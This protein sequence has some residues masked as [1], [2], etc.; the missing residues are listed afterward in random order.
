LIVRGH[1]ES[2]SRSRS[3]RRDF[4]ADGSRQYARK[5]VQELIDKTDIL[6]RLPRIGQVVPELGDDNIRFS[7]RRHAGFRHR[8]KYRLAQVCL[9]TQCLELA[10]LAESGPPQPEAAISTASRAKRA[11]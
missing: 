3:A 11:A 1:G 5:V 4:I 9:F 6:D 8:G 10:D 2:S 7:N